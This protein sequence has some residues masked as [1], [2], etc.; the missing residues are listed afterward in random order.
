MNESSDSKFV[1]RNWNTVNDQSNA[2]YSVGNEIIYGTEVVKSNIFD[3]NDAS[4]KVKVDI[5]IIG[6]TLANEVALKNCATFMK[7]I[8]KID[9]TTINDVEDLGLVMPIYNLSECS[10]NY[11]DTTDTFWFY[12]NDEATDFNVDIADDNA[13]KSFKYE[14]KLLGDTDGGNEILR[15]AT[16]AVPL[17]YLS[18]FW[19]SLKMSLINWK[20]ELKLNWSNHCV[21][22]ANGNGNDDADSNYIFFYQDK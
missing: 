4:I 8:T 9:V 10:T 12:S 3:Y 18:D 21:L 20:I 17:K 13:F 16:I 11:S 19:R 2:N 14:A 6:R 5:I 15:N 1:S 22:S 7:C